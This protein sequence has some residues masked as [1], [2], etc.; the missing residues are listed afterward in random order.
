MSLAALVALLLVVVV[1]LMA[2]NLAFQVLLVPH[3]GLIPPGVWRAW[4][5]WT[6]LPW[7]IETG[8]KEGR[9][10]VRSVNPVAYV[11]VMQVHYTDFSN[12]PCCIW[13]IIWLVPHSSINVPV[14]QVQDHIVNFDFRLVSIAGGGG[15][16]QLL[17]AD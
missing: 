5:Y 9:K 13:F 11:G 4:I 12:P 6:L 8:R 17:P 3:R 14:D 10:R 2:S 1:L 15:D 16:L 7:R